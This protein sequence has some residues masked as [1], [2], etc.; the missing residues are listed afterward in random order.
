MHQYQYVIYNSIMITFIRWIIIASTLVVITAV[1]HAYQQSQQLHQY[2]RSSSITF[3]QS[4][5]EH[6]HLYFIL[7]RDC[8]KK[9][10]FFDEFENVQKLPQC[11]QKSKIPASIAGQYQHMISQSVHNANIADI[12]LTA[13][14]QDVRYVIELGSTYL[15]TIGQFTLHIIQWCV[16]RS[17]A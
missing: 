15:A 13:P 5:V 16:D 9:E 3:G 4:N 7:D 8:W 6:I 17:N 1:G 12:Y 14:W 11:L 2:I 10:Y